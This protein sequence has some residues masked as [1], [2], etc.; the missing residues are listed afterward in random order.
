MSDLLLRV[1]HPGGF[2]LVKNQFVIE[3]FTHTYIK[4]VGIYSYSNILI[5]R[6]IHL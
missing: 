6:I 2:T 3:T 1:S 4:I 5:F